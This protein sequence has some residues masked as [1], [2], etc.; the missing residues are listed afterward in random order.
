MMVMNE[1]KMILQ[2]KFILKMNAT[3][4]QMRQRPSRPQK[5]WTFGVALRLEE[6]ATKCDRLWS[7]EPY[8]LLTVG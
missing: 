8:Y 2:K 7:Q 5:S 3:V 6:N 1:H 4:R